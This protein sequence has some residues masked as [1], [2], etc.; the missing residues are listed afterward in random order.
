MS[1]II[2]LKTGVYE[3]MRNLTKFV[4]ISRIDNRVQTQMSLFVVFVLLESD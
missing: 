1:R 3:F 2:R 4:V